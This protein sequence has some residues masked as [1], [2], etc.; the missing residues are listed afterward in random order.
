MGWNWTAYRRTGTLNLKGHFIAFM[1]GLSFP[2][3]DKKL[4]QT[5]IDCIKPEDR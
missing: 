1:E 4:L 2:N 3:F 5:P